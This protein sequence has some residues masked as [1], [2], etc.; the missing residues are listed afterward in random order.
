MVGG[1][2][3][4]DGGKRREDGHDPGSPAVL[5][6]NE[7]EELSTSGT[8]IRDGMDHVDEAE[9]NDDLHGK[10]N[11][12]EQRM[13]VILVVELALTLADLL[14]V[15]EVLHLH[16]VEGRHHAH[17]DDGVPLAPQRQRHENHL[18][19]ER[20]EEDGEPPVLR[21]VITRTHDGH[22]DVCDPGKQGY[23]PIRRRNTGSF[24]AASSE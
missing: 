9:Q 17:H 5:H 14:L 22:E 21:E 19:D 16:A 6:R 12:R 18:H 1:H 2:A 24:F 20:E 8:R 23:L 15:A 10:R 4:D 11:E 7:A 3:H 13:V